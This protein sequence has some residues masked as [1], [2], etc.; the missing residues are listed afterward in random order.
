MYYKPATSTYIVII[1]YFLINMIMGLLIEPLRPPW[2]LQGN[3]FTVSYTCVD[4]NTSALDYPGATQ[5]AA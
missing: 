2:L 3:S 5:A 1:M 4:L